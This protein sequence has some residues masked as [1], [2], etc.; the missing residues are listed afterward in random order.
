MYFGSPSVVAIIGASSAFTSYYKLGNDV[1][2]TDASGYTPSGS[3]AYI[4]S[5]VE[6]FQP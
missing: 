1:S 6:V 5:R 2:T 3:P 4:I